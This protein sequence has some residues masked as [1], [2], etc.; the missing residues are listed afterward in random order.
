MLL[1]L[2]LYAGLLHVGGTAE[3]PLIQHCSLGLRRAC[4]LRGLG[5]FTVLQLRDHVEAST[6]STAIPQGSLFKLL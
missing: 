2:E 1:L 4:D 6:L 3:G 5:L